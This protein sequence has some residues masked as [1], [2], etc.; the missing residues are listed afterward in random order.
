[1]DAFEVELSEKIILYNKG[2]FAMTLCV[3]EVHGTEVKLYFEIRLRRPDGSYSF[4]LK[5]Y[6]FET[7]VL[8]PLEFDVSDEGE[9]ENVVTITVTA[10]ERG[11]ASL[12]LVPPSNWEAI[13]QREVSDE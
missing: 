13:P 7:Q 11:R 1:M 8:T 12:T 10:F 5:P 9:D 6:P 3:E 2:E 4:T